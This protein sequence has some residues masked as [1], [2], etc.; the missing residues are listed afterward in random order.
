MYKLYYSSGAC[1]LAA[2]VVLNEIGADFETIST[3]TSDGSTRTPEFLKINPFGGIPVLAEDDNTISEGGAIIT[4]LCDKHNSPLLPKSGWERAVALKWLM[5]ANSTL[6]PAY[7]RTFWISKNLPQDQQD[8]ALKIAR[9]QIQTLWDTIEAQLEKQGTPYLAGKD[10]TAGD[11]LVTVIANWNP[12]NYKFGPKTKAL[13][14]SVSTRPA[15]Q[16]ALETEQVEYKA[17]A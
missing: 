6:H 3:P 16:K 4:Y 2:H 1:S 10:V 14:K 15:Y 8:A 7:S 5:F 11:I 17:A 9:T 13:L 12:Q